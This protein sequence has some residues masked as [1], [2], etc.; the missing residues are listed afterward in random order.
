MAGTAPFTLSNPT[1]GGAICTINGTTLWLRDVFNVNNSPVWQP[2]GTEV[3][4]SI[5]KAKHDLVIKNVAICYGRFSD[6]AALFP[7]YALNPVVGT[8]IFATDNPFVV[9]ALNGDRITFGN[10]QITKLFDLF[11]GVDEEFFA[12]AIEIT[13]II[14]GGYLPT[15]AGAYFVRDTTAAS[16]SAFVS[17][18]RLKARWQ[19]SWSGK[20]GFSTF[21]GKKG[22]HLGWMLDVK[23]DTTDGYGTTGMYIGKEGMIAALKCIPIGPT[24]PQV[25]TAQAIAA[26]LGALLSASAADIT[27]TSGSNSIGLK[28]AGIVSASTAFGIVP[29]RQGEVTWET[30]RGFSAGAPVAV[31]TMSAAADVQP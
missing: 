18:G 4:G 5:D 29:L 22:F 21:I 14:R 3:D 7:A 20:T 1:R 26:D 30:T 10:S 8:N 17:T 6:I 2:E 16:G 25:D 12:S 23:P 9:R 24:L 13:S 31:A 28:Q 27:L 19:A 11:L 15:D